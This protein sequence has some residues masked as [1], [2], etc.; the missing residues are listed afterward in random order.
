MKTCDSRAIGV[1]PGSIGESMRWTKREP[2]Q[3]ESLASLGLV[4]RAGLSGALQA[5]TKLSTRNGSGL[6]AT[7]RLVLDRGRVAG[8]R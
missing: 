8:T 4:N 2:C 1:R 3:P 7:R 6:S 5:Y